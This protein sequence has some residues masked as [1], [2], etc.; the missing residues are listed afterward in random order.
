MPVRTIRPRV[1]PVWTFALRK[2]PYRAEM[3]RYLERHPE[4]REE[5]ERATL[6]VLARGAVPIV[7]HVR[8]PFDAT[9]RY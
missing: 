4:F 5:L 6:A 9:H 1:A 2:G 7:P 8:E 3:T